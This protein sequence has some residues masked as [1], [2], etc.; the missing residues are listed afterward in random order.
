MGAEALLEVDCP[1]RREI[2]F[3]VRR[4]AEHVRAPEHVHVVLARVVATGHAVLVD[5]GARLRPK[6]HVFPR[7]IRRERDVR[8]T[9][10][11]V[12][13]HVVEAALRQI[14]RADAERAG[15]ELVAEREKSLGPRARIVLRAREA[16][17]LIIG[18]GGFMQRGAAAAH[19]VA[20]R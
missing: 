16:Q 3:R 7:H 18:N 2:E 13:L 8:L 1:G 6:P 5:D 4:L 17:R 10:A 9:D 11:P 12:G 15:R 14:V 19:V 20:G